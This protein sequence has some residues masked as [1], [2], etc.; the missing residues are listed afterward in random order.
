MLLMVVYGLAWAA[1]PVIMIRREMG[2]V[3]PPM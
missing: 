2:S 1:T 3:T